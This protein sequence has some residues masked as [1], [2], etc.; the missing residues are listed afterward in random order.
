MPDVSRAADCISLLQRVKL[1]IV[2]V[3]LARSPAKLSTTFKKSSQHSYEVSISAAF[4]SWGEMEGWGFRN[5]PKVTKPQVLMLAF[6]PRPLNLGLSGILTPCSTR[7]RLGVGRQRGP[8]FHSGT[9]SADA[10]GAGSAGDADSPGRGLLMAAAW[11]A[12]TWDPAAWG[13]GPRGRSCPLSGA[14]AVPHAAG[15]RLGWTWV[16]GARGGAAAEGDVQA[17]AGARSPFSSQ[18]P[19]PSSGRGR[20]RRQRARAPCSRAAGTPRLCVFGAD[21][22]SP[23]HAFHCRF[24]FP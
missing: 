9:D 23:H 22:P 13:P 11:P 4:Y 20:G 21:S 17:S 6:Q 2:I 15:Q 24:L 18:W 14:S 19:V 16:Q 10:E 5:I 1:L 8:F 7:Q 12:P 3:T